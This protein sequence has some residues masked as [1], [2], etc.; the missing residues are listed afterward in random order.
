MY[1]TVILIRA[2]AWYILVATSKAVKKPGITV[3]ID[4]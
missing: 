1:L 2:I 3:K 4:T